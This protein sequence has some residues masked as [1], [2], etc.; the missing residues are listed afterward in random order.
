[1]LFDLLAIC[2]RTLERLGK[3]QFVWNTGLLA[4]RVA[5][6]QCNDWAMG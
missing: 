5:H 2:S 6:S 3:S 4:A 1:M